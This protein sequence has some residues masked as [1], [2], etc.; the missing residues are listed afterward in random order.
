MSDAHVGH[1]GHDRLWHQPFCAETTVARRGLQQDADR[2]PVC[3]FL[4]PR[5]LT[6]ASI[7]HEGINRQAEAATRRSE[8]TWVCQRLVAIYLCFYLCNHSAS[9]NYL[10]DRTDC[11]QLPATPTKKGLLGPS[12]LTLRPTRTSAPMDQR[13]NKERAVCKRT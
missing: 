4:Q 10:V 13:E 11:D 2:T 3:I 9:V 7:F 12:S 1:V 6:E 5:W 8:S